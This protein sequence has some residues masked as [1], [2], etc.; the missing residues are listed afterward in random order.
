[1]SE[2]HTG[3]QWLK[4]GTIKINLV[5]TLL[6]PQDLTGGLLAGYVADRH[7]AIYDQQAQRP[8]QAVS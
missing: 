6:K 3:F 2:Q 8:K 1:M 4:V 7:R 5:Q